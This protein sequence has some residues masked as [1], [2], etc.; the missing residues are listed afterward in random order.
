MDYNDAVDNAQNCI[1]WAIIALADV[2]EAAL[3]VLE[4]K[5]KLDGLKAPG[6]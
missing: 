6:A 1:D 3:E 5:A 2:D 4:A